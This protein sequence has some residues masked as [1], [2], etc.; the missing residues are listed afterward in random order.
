MS[1]NDQNEAIQPVNLQ[2]QILQI[3][4]ANQQLPPASVQGQDGL[5]LPQYGHPQAI[6]PYFIHGFQGAQLP[7]WQGQLP[8]GQDLLPVGQGQF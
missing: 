7:V 1:V 8:V 2:P 4:Q 5:H 6:P 3:D